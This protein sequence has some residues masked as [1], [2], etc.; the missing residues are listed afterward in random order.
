MGYSDNPSDIVSRSFAAADAAHLDRDRLDRAFQG[1][2]HL[3]LCR[4]YLAERQELPIELPA[5]PIRVS[6][7]V[8]AVAT[9][10]PGIA[11]LF[12]VFAPA[13]SLRHCPS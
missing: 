7:R 3:D 1:P 9:L 10:K 8:I 13:N 12:P 5:C 4:S 2:M 11:W 6:E